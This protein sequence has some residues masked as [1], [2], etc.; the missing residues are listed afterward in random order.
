MRIERDYLVALLWG[1]AE[2]TL[3]FI[4]PD[5]WLT[6]LALRGTGRALAGS[7]YAALG[8]LIGGSIMYF[9]G[10]M[11]PDTALAVM[12]MV[13]AVSRG[14]IERVRVEHSSMGIVALFVGPFSGA[15]Y[16]LYA[17]MSGAMGIPLP[18][19]AFI[20]IPARLVRF[21]LLSVAAGAIARRVPWDARRKF[22]I[23][24]LLWSLF[25][26]LFFALMPD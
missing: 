24:L 19:F 4:V 8:A 1:F 21:V 23:T 13:P 11:D 18:L 3:F 6:L 5:V 25:Y 16:K 22:L 14:L 10:L 26:A 15:P 12:D 9:W 2:A 20:S 17:V 7:L